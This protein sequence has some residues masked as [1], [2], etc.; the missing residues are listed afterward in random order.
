MHQA[1]LEAAKSPHRIEAPP[2]LEDERVVA[3]TGEEGYRTEIMAGRHALVSD[4]PVR[5]GG[6]DRHIR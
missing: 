1:Q 6:T 3:H 2:P 4:E 5:L